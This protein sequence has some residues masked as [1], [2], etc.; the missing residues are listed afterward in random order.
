[1]VKIGKSVKICP[2]V[3]IGANSAIH[4]FVVLGF[5]PRGK[6]SGELKLTIGEGAVIRPF[7]TIYAGNKIGKCF[8]SG[9]GTSIRENNVIAD[10]VSVGSNTTLE[11][12]NRIGPGTRIH[13]L[14]FLE[15]TRIGKYV[16]IGPRTVFLDDP[17]PMN[18]PKYHD[19][20]GGA[21][22]KKLAKI[23]GGCTILPGIT[24]G[25]N[26]LV[27]AGACVT[28]DVPDNTVVIGNPAK[29]V[30]KVD[31]LKCYPGFFERPYLWAPYK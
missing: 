1:M 7:T 16:F 6:K 19:C 30:K 21:T 25:K 14:C 8:Q 31:Q 22:V 13:S 23:G 17:H 9:Q 27:G 11:F 12:D 18:C 3:E 26:A 29:V 5:P 24:I 4:D 2:G 10:N 15:S 28:K 20:L